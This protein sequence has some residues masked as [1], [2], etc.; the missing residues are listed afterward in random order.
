[1]NV[2]ITIDGPAG[3][4]KSTLAKNLAR[5][6]GVAYLDTGAMYRTLGLHL[7]ENVCLL[8]DKEL[9]EKLS[10]FSFTLEFEGNSISSSGSNIT[11]STRNI[12]YCNGKIVGEEIREERVGALASLVGTLPLVRQA[13]QKYQ[14]EIG[15]STGIVVEGR[16]MGTVVFPHALCKFFLEA[17]VTTRAERRFL[18]LQNKNLNANYDKILEDMQLRDMQDCQRKTDP[19][20]PAIDACIIDTSDLSIEQVLACMVAE[21]KKVQEKIPDKSME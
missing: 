21:V 14:R 16:D 2:V 10:L 11:E 19:L 5:A 18:E 7:G 6:F 8:S 3:V 4:G 13:L 17:R 15:E 12:L 20:K 1:M 9:E